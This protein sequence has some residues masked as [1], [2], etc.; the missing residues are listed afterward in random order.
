L[1]DPIEALRRALA[2]R[3]PRTLEGPETRAAVALVLRGDSASASLL[4]VRR[5]E[6]DGDPWSGHVAFPGGHLEPYDATPRDAAERETLEELGLDLTGARFLGSLDDV[7]GRIS[8]ITVSP[9]AYVIEGE[10][11]LR[12][13]PE[14]AAAFWLPLASLGDPARRITLHVAHDTGGASYPAIR[15]DGDGGAPLWGLSL[16]I[17]EQLLDLASGRSAAARDA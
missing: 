2:L 15:L 1:S 16:R 17:V 5:A 12:I 11:P 6:R 10:P 8:A 3:A 4:L 13:A 9:F 7:H 14:L